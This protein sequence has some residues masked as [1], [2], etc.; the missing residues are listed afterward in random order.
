M[1]RFC[2][3]SHLKKIKE[4]DLLVFGILCCVTENAFEMLTSLQFFYFIHNLGNLSKE[5][6]FGLTSSQ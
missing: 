5:Q 2:V 6:P 4:K 1:L 3:E